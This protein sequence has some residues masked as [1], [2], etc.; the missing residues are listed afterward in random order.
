MST[1]TYPQ[2]NQPMQQFK[3]FKGMG[4]NVLAVSDYSRYDAFYGFN[5]VVAVIA[6]D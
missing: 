5:R 4:Q 2:F 6:C 1:F 3:L